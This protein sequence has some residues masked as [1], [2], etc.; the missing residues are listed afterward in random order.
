M[1]TI[2]YALGFIE[3]S[4]RS[5]F[6]LKPPLPVEDPVRFYRSGV[7]SWPENPNLDIEIRKKGI[8]IQIF[9]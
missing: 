2:Q 6:S 7:K 3:N 5:Y 9:K 8:E 4:R 1:E